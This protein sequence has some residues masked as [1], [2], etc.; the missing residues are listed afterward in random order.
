MVRIWWRGLFSTPFGRELESY[1][2]WTLTQNAAIRTARGGSAGPAR[3]R[4]RAAPPRLENKIDTAARPL[5]PAATA[6]RSACGRHDNLFGPNSPVLLSLFR[7]SVHAFGYEASTPLDFWSEL[8]QTGTL[9]LARGRERQRLFAVCAVRLDHVIA[10][11]VIVVPV[12][13]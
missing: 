13:Q 11:H 1:P 4:S 2:K 5:W 3:S 12:V 10:R 6:T 9:C 8:T 7:S